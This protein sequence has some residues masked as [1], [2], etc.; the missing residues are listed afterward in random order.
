MLAVARNAAPPWTLQAMSAVKRYAGSAIIAAVV[1]PRGQRNQAPA[2]FSGGSS[3]DASASA[4]AATAVPSAESAGEVPMFSFAALS[5][6]A[7]AEAVFDLSAPPATGDNGTPKLHACKNCQRAK[8]ACM[9]QRP[10]ARCVRLQARA[11][12]VQYSVSRP[13]RSTSR[14]P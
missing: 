6:Y 12:F 9:D 2:D 3:S 11:P 5:E 4:T 10:C 13:P 7:Q 14:S 1:S 8:T